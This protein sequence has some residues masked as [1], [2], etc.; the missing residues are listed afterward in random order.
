MWE[1][2]LMQI[3]KTVGAE[4]LLPWFLENC[5]FVGRT[6]ILKLRAARADDDDVQSFLRQRIVWAETTFPDENGFA[7][8]WHIATDPGTLHYFQAIERD[9]GG[10]LLGTAIAE[11]HQFIEAI[12]P[13]L[14]SL[15]L[16]TGTMPSAT[17]IG[18]MLAHQ[19]LHNTPEQEIPYET[20]A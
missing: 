15:F 11:C 10:S 2:V 14:V 6:F 1:M 9:I 12:L 20:R 5:K 16:A 17:V 8:A 13:D 18:Q 7:R 3:L 19:A 4:K